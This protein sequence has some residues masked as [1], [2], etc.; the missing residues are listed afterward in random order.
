MN[1]EAL[2]LYEDEDIFSPQ[3]EENVIPVVMSAPEASRFVSAIRNIRE[4]K[5]ELKAIRD[6]EVSQIDELFRSQVEKLDQSLVWYEAPL[7]AYLKAMREKNP[8]YTLHTPH[9]TVS[10]RKP[11]EEWK[12]PED[13]DLFIAFLEAQGLPFVRVRKEIDR[14]SIREQCRSLI[15]PGDDGSSVRSVCTADGVVLEGIMVEHTPETLVY[16][17]AK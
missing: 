16:H 4:K 6:A 15:I 7:K 13:S 9:G 12:Y 5:D 8:K 1:A 14:K 11:G 2:A 10:L 3:P 17:F